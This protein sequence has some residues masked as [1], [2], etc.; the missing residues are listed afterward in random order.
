MITMKNKIKLPSLNTLSNPLVIF[1][2]ATTCLYLNSCSRSA[3]HKPLIE[4]D[5]QTLDTLLHQGKKYHYTLIVKEG[6]TLSGYWNLDNQIL[7]F[8]N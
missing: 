7:Y 6:D 3:S 4:K 8:I 5:F 1:L 2:L